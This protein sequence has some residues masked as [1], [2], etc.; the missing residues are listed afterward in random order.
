MYIYIRLS[1][2]NGLLTIPV[3]CSTDQYHTGKFSTVG[4]LSEVEEHATT[5]GGGG[6]N[7]QPAVFHVAMYRLHTKGEVVISLGNQARGVQPACTMTTQNSKIRLIS[8][9][10]LKS[11]LITYLST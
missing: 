5:W 4:Q 8:S 2:Y 10:A 9:I 11:R 6:L 3:Q 7:G 1:T